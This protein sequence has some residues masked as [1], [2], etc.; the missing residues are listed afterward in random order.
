MAGAFVD[1]RWRT[2]ELPQPSYPTQVYHYTSIQGVE[3][4]LNSRTLWASLLHFM[5]DSRE[6]LYA[7]DLIRQ[8]ITQRLTHRDDPNWIL[9]ISEL[10]ES[11]AQIERINICVFVFS[12]SSNQLSQWRAYCPAEGGYELCFQFATLKQHMEFHGFELRECVYNLI[13]QKQIIGGIADNIINAVTALPDEKAVEAA[14]QVAIQRISRELA[15]VAPLLKHPDFR[16]EREWRAFGLIPANDPRMSYHLKG[17]V[18]VPHCTLSLESEEAAFPI[19][20][21]LVGPNPHQALALR[22]LSALLGSHHI[23][24][25]QSA[26]P[27]RSF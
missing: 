26:T 27:L 16:E 20:H 8:D 19:T 17:S 23:S 3:G 12:A 7:L 6:W 21:I 15:Q 24:I 18:A 9:F 14:R 22:G 10:V 1:A 5:N 4:I 25:G 11:L 13:V 2:V